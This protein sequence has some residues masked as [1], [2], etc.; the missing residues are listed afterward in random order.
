MLPA[1]RE[2]A[3][4]RSFLLHSSLD[5]YVHRVSYES[6][7]DSLPPKTEFVLFIKLSELQK[8]VASLSVEH[9]WG[10]DG[11]ASYLVVSLLPQDSTKL[12]HLCTT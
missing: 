2:T 5:S 1:E 7:I 12:A 11:Q 8:R 9:H 3:R 6:V 4:E 10:T